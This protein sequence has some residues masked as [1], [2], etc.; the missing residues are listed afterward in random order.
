MP[1]LDT[2][3]D[4]A[5]G[6]DM[7]LAVT[8]GM[9]L[10]ANEIPPQYASKSATWKR[11]YADGLA[12]GRAGMARIDADEKTLAALAGASKN[13][14]VKQDDL[15]AMAIIESTGNRA[16]GTN[17]FG[18]TGLMQ[19]GQDAA[20]DLGMSYSKMRG[21][22]NVGNNAL[23]GARYWKLNEERLNRNVPKDPLHM[24]L[25][26][27]QG[28]GGTNALMDTLAT[29][30]GAKATGAQRNNL[31]GDLKKQLG[32]G[33]TQQNFYDYWA[34]KMQAIQDVIAAKKAPK[35]A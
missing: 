30:P 8:D 22:E 1:E 17:A 32:K 7:Q 23:A 9:E 10:A 11:G 19:M 6:A 5:Q 29:N 24:Y 34:G 31:P 20:S 26:H 12:Q 16:V 25:A 35:L 14:G 27:Q 18:Y 4:A 13:T 33:A 28:A 15:T 2:S 3:E 21:A